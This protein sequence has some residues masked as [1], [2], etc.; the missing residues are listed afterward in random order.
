MKPSLNPFH[1]VYLGWVPTDLLE[2]LGISQNAYFLNI[3][4]TQPLATH[5]V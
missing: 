3:F 4:Q 5:S 1:Q 2:V